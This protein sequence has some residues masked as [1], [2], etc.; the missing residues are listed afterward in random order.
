M[1]TMSNLYRAIIA[2]TAAFLMTATAFAQSTILVVDQTRILRESEV[3]KHIKR[4]IE[5]I[6]KSME[7]ELKSAISPLEVEGKT[8]QAELKA[9]GKTDISTRPDL[10][11]RLT[12]FAGKSQKQQLEAAYK[13]RELAKTEA[14]AYR[15]VSQK[16]EEILK[17]VVA[18]RNAD[19]VI[20]RSAVIYGKPADV[21]DLVMSRL[22]SQMRTVAVVR[23]RL[24]RKQ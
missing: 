7:T 10:K 5:S 18:E 9:L 6:G 8:L 14:V 2:V 17:V 15:K 13:Q 20:D 21:T 4:Q 19:V 12:S 3:G 23:E 16:L 24:P 22:N 11:S 1:K